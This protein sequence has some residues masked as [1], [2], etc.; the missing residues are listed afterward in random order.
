MTEVI[1]NNADL[2]SIRFF[3]NCDTSI[4]SDGNR[5]IGSTMPAYCNEVELDALKNDIRRVEH[6]LTAGYIKPEA[7]IKVEEDLS[8]MKSRRD[9]IEETRPKPTGVLKDKMKKAYDDL[10]VKIKDSNFPT[11]KLQQ[12]KVNI[13]QEYKRAN[14]PCIDIPRGLAMAL[15]VRPDG[16]KAAMMKVN[17]NEASR[18]WQTLGHILGESTDT[19]DLAR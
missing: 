3:A 9:D 18:C 10:G 15:N 11:D 13:Y 4:N 14:H 16:K 12:G 2:E 6:N 7:R 17:R 1:I 5:V 19:S 8:K